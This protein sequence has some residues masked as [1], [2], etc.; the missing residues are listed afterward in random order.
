MQLATVLKCGSGSTAEVQQVA[1]S[2]VG[3][4][5]GT[6]CLAFGAAC[7]R[8]AAAVVTECDVAQF[9]CC[10]C[11]CGADPH[12]RHCEANE[13][14]TCC[15][16]SQS[17]SRRDSNK[18]SQIVVASYPPACCYS[19]PCFSAY[20]SAAS[21]PL[22]ALTMWSACWMVSDIAYWVPPECGEWR[23]SATLR[24]L[25]LIVAGGGAGR[26]IGL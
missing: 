12:W 25:I 3:K 10:C 23:V 18:H 4:G 8:L 7:C 9:I 19:I 22:C 17:A 1:R 6:S 5:G 21:A 16:V 14:S 15:K 20:S 2:W 26:G 24:V 13:I 11:C